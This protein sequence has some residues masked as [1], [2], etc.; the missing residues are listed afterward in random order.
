MAKPKSIISSTTIKPAI[1]DAVTIE[2]K[3]PVVGHIK[4]K[5]I[6]VDQNL[7]DNIN[8]TRKDIDSHS[9]NQDIHVSLKEKDI[10]NNKESKQ[11]SQ[12]KVNKVMNSLQVHMNDNT[13]HL[14]KSEKE[15]FKDKYT[16]SE[17]RNL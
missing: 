7:R 16:K 15:L 11:G 17:V 4:N 6:H 2:H 1:T 13:V 10:W 14:T 12:A 3:D 8:Y 9:S 5:D